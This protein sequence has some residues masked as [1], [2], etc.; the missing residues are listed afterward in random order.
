VLPFACALELIHTYSIIHDDLPA[1]D[2]DRLRRGK[3]TSHV[4]FGEALAI[5]AGDALLTES[6]RVMG[7]AAAKRGNH[8]AHALQVLVEIATAAGARGMVAGQAADMDAENTAFDLPMVE[9]IHIR[10]TG[11]L[12]RAAVR[13]GAIL[14]GATPEQL[15][16]LTRYGEFLG[17]AFQ[18]ADDV[19]DAEGTTSVTGKV[20]RRDQDRRKA[21]FPAVLGLSATKHRAHELLTDALR[22][23]RPLG[24]RAEP[25]RGI[26]RAIVQRA[27][28]A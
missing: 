6:F 8:Q 20:P 10:K 1:M 25:L 19:L 22:E 16:R 14:G 4:I 18:V 2:D 23:I 26:A 13:A 12:I 24:E 3:P 5:L 21:T 11:A 28:P 15:R 9:W 27:C 17:L 7:A